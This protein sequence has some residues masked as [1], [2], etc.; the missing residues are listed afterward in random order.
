[1]TIYFT[2]SLRAIQEHDKKNYIRKKNYSR[3][4]S[5]A[6]P[7]SSISLQYVIFVKSYPIH[8]NLKNRYFYNIDFFLWNT[9]KK[10]SFFFGILE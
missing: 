10:K 5:Q 2:I 4:F 7:K 9:K 1:M 6:L 3:S 8:K